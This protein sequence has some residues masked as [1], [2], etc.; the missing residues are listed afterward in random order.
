MIKKIL[1]FLI[2]RFYLRRPDL[3]HDIERYLSYTGF[4]I[5]LTNVIQ[6]SC[7]LLNLTRSYP[8]PRLVRFEVSSLCNLNCPMCPQPSKMTRKKQLMDFTVYRKVI[9]KT[10]INQN[11]KF[12]NRDYIYN[13][14][15]NSRKY[16]PNIKIRDNIRRGIIKIGINECIKSLDKNDALEIVIDEKIDK[17]Y[18]NILRKYAQIHGVKIKV[19]DDLHV[20]KAKCLVIRQND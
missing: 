20:N 14:E 16:T 1:S 8:A 4:Y 17:L 5:A 19:V 7:F 12:P 18:E 13:G 6:Q 10:L 3:S 11:K 2:S 15:I 9:D